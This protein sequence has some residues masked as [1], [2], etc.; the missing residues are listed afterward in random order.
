[1][2]MLRSLRRQMLEDLRHARRFHEAVARDH[3]DE[4]VGDPV[5]GDA[6]VARHARHVLGLDGQ[7]DVA[8]VQDAVVLQVVH[9]R[10]GRR[11]SDRR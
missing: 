6:L 4:G 11:A 8:L 7:D 5:D 10:G 1:M 9:E 3:A 2:S